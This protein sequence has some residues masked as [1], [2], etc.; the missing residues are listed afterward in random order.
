M[1]VILIKNI[2]VH[3]AHPDFWVEIQTVISHG[4]C[5]NTAQKYGS[6]M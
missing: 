5:L 3:M 6:T 2:V 1:I 4:V